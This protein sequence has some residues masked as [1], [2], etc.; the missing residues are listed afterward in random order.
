MKTIL[1]QG[2]MPT[3]T[4]FLIDFYKPYKKETVAGFDFYVAKYKNAKII[5]SQT[6]IGIMCA[7][8]ATTIGIQKYHPDIVINQGCS[9]GA[10]IDAKVG[11]I[12]AGES[13]IYINA[14]ATLVKSAGEVSNSLEWKPHSVRSVKIDASS[15]LIKR[16][17]EFDLNIPCVC[18]GSGDMFNRESDRI[19]YLHKS[20]NHYCEDMET[21]ASYKVCQDFGVDHIA[22]RIISNNE[23]LFTAKDK[24]THTTIQKYTT[25]FVDY[26]LTSIEK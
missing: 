10:I 8:Q 20:F 12:V 9:G 7:T 25:R 6:Q 4:N 15:W 17:Q 1:I 5:I 13:A 18:L 11:N 3:E 26:L 22:F 24:S 19:N 23:L 14:F 16:V 2:A 21:V